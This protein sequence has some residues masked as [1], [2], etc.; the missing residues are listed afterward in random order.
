M[1]KEQNGLRPES[2]PAETADGVLDRVTGGWK[3][4]ES[5]PLVL[6][7]PVRGIDVGAKYEPGLI[8]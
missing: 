6:E 2:G 1:E 7:L 3:S 8:K 4:E 5:V